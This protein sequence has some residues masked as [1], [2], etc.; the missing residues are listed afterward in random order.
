M[1]GQ[2]LRLEFALRARTTR[3]EIADATVTD[4]LR[5]TVE[6]L[7][8]MVV[9]LVLLVLH[10]SPLWLLEFVAPACGGRRPAIVTECDGNHTM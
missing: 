5:C 4:Q 3:G 2:L 10:V 8:R 7:R 9:L 6:P 1:A